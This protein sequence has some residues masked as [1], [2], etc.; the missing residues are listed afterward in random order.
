[1]AEPK[2]DTWMPF[3]V[4]DYLAATARLTTEQHGAYLLLL[5]D[6]WRNGPPPNDDPVLAQ[7]ARMTPVAWK[8][9]KPA[10][11]GFFD[12]RDGRLIQRRAERERE[13]AIDITEKRRKAGAASAL[14]RANA[15]QKGNTCSTHVAANEEQNA[16]PSQSHI[17]LDKSNGEDA[18]QVFWA[19]AKAFLAPET[20]GDPGKLVGAWCRDYGKDA[21]AQAIT[22]AQLERPVQ[23]IPFIIGCLKQSG[24]S[25]GLIVPC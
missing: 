19:N 25:G 10:L 21:T 22:R 4:G 8:K 24:E 18:D 15:Q 2:S 23:R 16:R 13:R 14:A 12:E 20:K 1:M 17:P 7:I 11:I 9:A 6:Y 3:Y 5:L